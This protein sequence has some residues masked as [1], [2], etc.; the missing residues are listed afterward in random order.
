MNKNEAVGIN[1]EREEP[2]FSRIVKR[3]SVSSGVTSLAR[4]PPCHFLDRETVLTVQ[5]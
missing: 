1:S 3:L 5:S 4:L 2:V